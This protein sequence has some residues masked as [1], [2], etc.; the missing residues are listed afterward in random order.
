MLDCLAGALNRPCDTAGQHRHLKVIKLLS[1]AGNTIG[2]PVDNAL[3]ADKIVAVHVQLSN[4]YA[5]FEIG[6]RVIARKFLHK[7]MKCRRANGV[8]IVPSNRWTIRLGAFDGVPGDPDRPKAFAAERLA[9]L[10]PADHSP[11]RLQAKQGQPGRS[12]RGRTARAST[13][14]TRAALMIAGLMSPWKRYFRLRRG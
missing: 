9:K 4:D 13:R 6:S 14:S 10:R 1:R 8:S 7:S 2:K 3:H 11:D 5:P 12:R